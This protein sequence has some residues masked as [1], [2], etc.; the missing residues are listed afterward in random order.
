MNIIQ[1]SFCKKPFQSFG[2]RIC[3]NCLEKIDKDFV[4]VRD[5]IYENRKADMDT[6]SEETGVPKQIIL[7]LLKE[8]RLIIDDPEDSGGLLHCEV[9]RKP[10][11]T[12]RMCANCKDNVSSTMQKSMETHKEMDRQRRDASLKG[13]AK[14]KN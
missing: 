6:V 9:C 14:V 5:Y 4:I 12:G 1:C 3:G 10:I 13:A 7:H 8:G 11:R 2:G